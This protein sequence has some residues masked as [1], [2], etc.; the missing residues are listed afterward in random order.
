M[1]PGSPEWWLVA[2]LVAV[3]RNAV[4]RARPG[5]WIMTWEAAQEYGLYGPVCGELSICLDA[6]LASGMIT[7]LDHPRR[8]VLSQD[9]GWLLTASVGAHI[10]SARVFRLW[11]AG[12]PPWVG[13]CG[14]PAAPSP[15]PPAIT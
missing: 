6:H 5:R 2:A 13:R 7:L 1:T 10:W 12:T 8:P 4:S 14:W 11:V 15:T 9:A 3:A